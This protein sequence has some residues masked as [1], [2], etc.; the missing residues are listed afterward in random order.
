M[1]DAPEEPKGE[2]RNTGFKRA[3]FSVGAFVLVFTFVWIVFD[4]MALALLFALVFGGGAQAA[5]AARG[6]QKKT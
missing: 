4:N 3:G 5:Q 1:S 2:D 6:T